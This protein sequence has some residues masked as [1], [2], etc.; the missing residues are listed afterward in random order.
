MKRSRQTIVLMMA[1]IVIIIISFFFTSQL[2]SA[3]QNYV[4]G[5]GLI[6]IFLS[7]IGILF[8]YKEKSSGGY[9]GLSV[10]TACGMN[11]LGIFFFLLG[12]FN[13][14]GVNTWDIEG[15]PFPV[16]QSEPFIILWVISC[17][18]FIIAAMIYEDQNLKRII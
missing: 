11:T 1:S 10:R 18:L 5:I 4:F 8:A 2:N 9:R 15:G 12:L 7:L 13:P 17:I 6:F 16:N 3:G 14:V